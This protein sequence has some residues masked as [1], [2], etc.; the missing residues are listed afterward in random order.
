MTHPSNREGFK[1]GFGGLR[2]VLVFFG[3]SNKL[4]DLG[5]FEFT[6]KSAL[7][8]IDSQE[9]NRHEKTYPAFPPTEGCLFRS[10]S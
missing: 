4:Q 8:H 6:R 10:R 9:S 1:D 3:L 5:A 7:L 2:A